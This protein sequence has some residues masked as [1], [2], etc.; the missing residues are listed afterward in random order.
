MLFPPTSIAPST[1]GE[2]LGFFLDT[3]AT[4]DQPLAEYTGEVITK[5]EFERRKKLPDHVYLTELHDLYLD[6][7]R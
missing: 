7:T 2:K 3:A 4:T 6:A 5:A 1:V